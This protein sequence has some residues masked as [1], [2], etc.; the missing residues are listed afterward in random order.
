MLLLEKYLDCTR[1]GPIWFSW[2]V[3]TWAIQEVPLFY[4]LGVR[5][6]EDA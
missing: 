2:P 1:T 3:L 5:Y 6:G 4:A